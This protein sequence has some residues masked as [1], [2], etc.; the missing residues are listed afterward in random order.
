MGLRFEE[1]RQRSYEVLGLVQE[2]LRSDWIHDDTGPSHEQVQ[3]MDEA[4]KHL[5]AAKAALA[6]AAGTPGT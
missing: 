5:A 6:R 1:V 2:K 3:A 4:R